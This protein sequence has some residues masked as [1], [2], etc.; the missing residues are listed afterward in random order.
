MSTSRR[1]QLSELMSLA[2]Q[3]VKRNGF[4]MS[5]ALKCAWANIKLKAKMYKGI[6]KF[7]GQPR[8]AGFIDLSTIVNS[9][10]P[11]LEPEGIFNKYK[12]DKR[13]LSLITLKN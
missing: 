6:V 13:V 9:I 12:I 3:F 2:W 7:P 10:K 11:L 8:G 5:E 4:T 1:N